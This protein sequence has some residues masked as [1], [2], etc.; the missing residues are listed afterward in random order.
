L[1][2][3]RVDLGRPAVIVGVGEPAVARE[4]L[5]PVDVAV[6]ARD[7]ADL[8][9]ADRK[10]GDDLP[11]LPVDAADLPDVLRILRNVDLVVLRAVA[12]GVHHESELAD[13]DVL[14]VLTV[15]VEHLDV[16]PGDRVLYPLT[17]VLVLEWTEEV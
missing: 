1:L 4:S 16:G 15:L 17:V 10:V 8:V 14:E 7:A 6:L 9:I 5:A 11:Q 12:N 3:E 2:P 13:A